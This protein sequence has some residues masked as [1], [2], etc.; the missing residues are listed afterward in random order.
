MQ[1]VAIFALP[2]HDETTVGANRYVGFALIGATGSVNVRIAV[3]IRHDISHI[4][5]DEIGDFR[6]VDA[7]NV[8]RLFHRNGR[9]IDVVIS[10]SNIFVSA[11]LGTLNDNVRIDV[12]RG[13]F[14]RIRR[15]GNKERV[16]I[17]QSARASEGDAE[18]IRRARDGFDDD[19]DRADRRLHRAV[20]LVGKVRASRIVG[21]LEA[22]SLLVV[23][24]SASNRRIKRRLL[25]N[26]I[27]GVLDIL[28][29][30]IRIGVDHDTGLLSFAIIGSDR[31]D[32]VDG[33]NHAARQVID[34]RIARDLQRLEHR[35]APLRTNHLRDRLRV[36]RA[37]EILQA[38]FLERGAILKIADVE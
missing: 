3:T 33:R 7:E 20:R 26:F 2:R 29:R 17:R 37:K 27:E 32:V 9:L 31:L 16:L 1:N 22:V 25:R 11:S 36:V 14:R 19:F 13:D 6:R 4:V 23:F 24:V 30:L 5:E 15:G 28:S 21:I 38:Q 10:R 12:A 34:E 35:L 18:L 8:A